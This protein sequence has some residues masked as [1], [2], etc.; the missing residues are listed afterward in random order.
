MVIALDGTL[1][2]ALPDQDIHTLKAVIVH[3]TK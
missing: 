3:H 2:E 1:L